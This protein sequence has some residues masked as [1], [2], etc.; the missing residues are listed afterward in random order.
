MNFGRTD[1]RIGVSKTKFDEQADF[2]VRL[3]VAPQK[4]NQNTKKLNNLFV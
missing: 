2:E 4:P 3:A 1:L